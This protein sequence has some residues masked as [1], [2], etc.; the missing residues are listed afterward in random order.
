[1]SHESHAIDLQD[2]TVH[3]GKAVA[4]DGVSLAIPR[5][6]VY[7]LL[8]RNG[9]GKSSLTRCLLGV[10]KPTRGSA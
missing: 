5:G 6:S 8:G 2:L 9:A 1:M 3:Y 10:Q 4:V 7:A